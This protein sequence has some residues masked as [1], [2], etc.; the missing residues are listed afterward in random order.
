[1]GFTDAP[2]QRSDAADA[3]AN[4]HLGPDLVAAR[5]GNPSL[6]VEPAQQL[7]GQAAQIPTNTG[8]VG[9]HTDYFA[10][11]SVGAALIF[12]FVFQVSY[13]LTYYR[14]AQEQWSYLLAFN[15]FNLYVALGVGA[16]LLTPW[17]RRHWR[18]AFW[19]ASVALVGGTA[20]ISLATRSSDEL[21]FFVLGLVSVAGF[22]LPWR[23]WWQASLSL[24]GLAAMLVVEVWCPS[25]QIPA[26][27]RWLMLLASIGLGQFV[28][29][30]RESYRRRL[31]DQLAELIAAD[32]KMRAE[33]A[34]REAAQSKVKERET[35]LQEIFDASPDVITVMSLEG[36]KYSYM[37]REFSLSGYSK[38]EFIGRSVAELGIW[39]DANQLE[40]LFVRLRSGKS[41]RNMEFTLRRKD[42]AL[43]PCMISATVAELGGESS[44]VAVARD[45]SALK[46]GQEVNAFWAAVCSSSEVAI[47]TA[48]PDFV[49]NGWNPAA[50]RLYGYSGQEALGKSMSFILPADSEALVRDITGALRRGQTVGELEQQCLRKDGRP[51]VCSFTISPVYNETGALI[52]YSALSYDITARKQ[53][54]QRLAQREAKFRA[55]FDSNPDP[56]S[57]NLLESGRFVEINERWVQLFA[58]SREEVLGRRPIDLGLW[59]DVNSLRAVHR[60]LRKRGRLINYEAMFRAKDGRQFTGLFSAVVTEL[61]GADVVL[62]FLRDISERKLAER[63][64][65]ESEAKLRQLFEATPDV[66]VVVSLSDNRILEVNRAFVAMTGFTREE[67]LGSTALDLNLWADV[68]QRQ[69]FYAQLESK[70]LVKNMEAV[71]R[72]KDGGVIQMLFS[73]AKGSLEGEP[74]I[75]TIS[76]DVTE[77]KRTGAELR[78]SE[79]KFRQVFD[80][81]LDA[82]VVAGLTDGIIIDVNAEFTRRVGISREEAIG[83]TTVEVGIWAREADYAAFRESLRRLG[84]V[85]N[86]EALFRRDDGTFGVR[87][88]NSS[89]AEIG[90]RRCV[91]TVSRDISALKEIERQLIESR[92]AALT[93]SKAKSEFLS[94]M[95]HEIRTPMNAIMGAGDILSETPLNAE[96]RRY[97]E[98][99]RSNASALLG[100]INN[101]LDLARIESGRM[102][103][104]HSDFE[105]DR[106]IEETA[107]DMAVRAHQKSLELA[108]RILP[109][110]PLSLTGD[111]MRLRQCLVN[112][113]GNAIKFT[114]KG[115]IV[116]TVE[117]ARGQPGAAPTPAVP[118]NAVALTKPAAMANRAAG[119]EGEPVWLHFVVS[120]TGIGIPQDKLEA[121]FLDFTQVDSSTTRENSGTGL[122]LAIVRRLVELNGGQVWVESK[123]GAGSTFHLTLAFQARVGAPQETSPENVALAGSRVLVVDD[124]PVNRLIAKDSLCAAGARVEEARLGSEALAMVERAASEGEPFQV[125]LL[126]GRMPGMNGF[127]VARHLKGQTGR[128]DG[129]SAAI[130]LML[131]SDDLST[132]LA[133]ASEVG[134]AYYLVKPLKRAELKSVVAAALKRA[135]L[136]SAQ[137]VP[138]PAAAPGAPA[139]R[140][141]PLRI[142]LAEDSIDNR[143][144]IKAFLAHTPYKLDMAEN[145]EQAVEKFIAAAGAGN[146]YDLV[147]MDIQMPVMDGHAAA[148]MIR[149]WELDQGVKPTPIVALTASAFTHDV[150]KSLEAGCD[151]HVSKP[152][153][154]AALHEAIERACGRCRDTPDDNGGRV[155]AAGGPGNGMRT[156]AVQVVAQ[157]ASLAPGFL[158]RKREDLACVLAALEHGDYE[159]IRS[160]AH[161]MKGEGGALGFDTISEIGA[162]LESAAQ[163]ADKSAMRKWAAVLSDYLARVRIVG[164]AAE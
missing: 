131:G 45:I 164:A 116:L 52:G 143:M 86:Q 134:V 74:C 109:D 63:K 93:A 82:I 155:S 127:E 56:V 3:D 40:E 14:A 85:R 26:A 152:L 64:L 145:G 61:D 65:A 71:F 114:T 69:A 111:S 129:R 98:L 156:I 125:V 37:N 83:K 96:Q 33:I 9:E 138:T 7:A 102:H 20:G 115:Q 112:L 104:E 67:A 50:E 73:A 66:I 157:F 35:L 18:A 79:E 92:E 84:Y 30:Q 150:R 53:A 49:Y 161:M 160:L 58:L 28:I 119:A 141:S 163:A 100:L 142:L 136:T 21:G 24:V 43:L 5:T 60:M 23:G 148:R 90:G 126:D 94:S 39:A 75:F 108:V 153:R 132:Q 147:L 123:V 4:N 154:K 22:L 80:S 12:T 16:L 38:G 103:V 55:I 17:F 149:Q 31:G 27:V 101:I 6:F 140:R 139:G 54:E 44:I 120:D 118:A 128:E 25:S 110:V 158:K 8:L 62:S 2:E 107:Q 151:A 29:Y 124:T 95:S 11:G 15:T 36:G 72:S 1:M 162:L 13:L 105:L 117:M 135:P 146:K 42:G 57:V 137:A 47:T 106:L 41:V 48:T 99:M 51:I 78:A 34:E 122:G 113:L 81:A 46:R 76:R 32:R 19:T 87:L 144:I 59:A 89:K 91:V 88:L 70:G 68:A 133:R 97:L 10:V 159:T 130:I 121:I 77:L